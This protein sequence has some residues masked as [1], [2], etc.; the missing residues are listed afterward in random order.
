MNKLL[1]F[2]NGEFTE[3]IAGKFIESFNPSEGTAHLLVADSDQADIEAAV[4]AA[5][6][7][8]PAWSALR[9]EE[10]ARFLYRIADLID[11]R[12]AELARAESDD[13][14][15]PVWLAAEMDIPR[16]AA[17]FRFF[18]GCVLHQEDV[19][20]RLDRDTFNYV[21]R[22]PL[23]VAGLISPWNLPLYLLTWKIA[24]A[25]AYGNTCV[26]K[27][28]ELTSLTASILC[29]IV[30]EAGVPKGVVNVVFGTGPKAGAA[31]VDHPDVPLISFTGGTMTG[32]SI[33]R[34]AAPKF[35]KLSLELGGKNPNIIF[36]DADLEKAV[37]T[38]IRSSFLNQGE[39]CLCGS[40]IYV[41][42]NIHERFLDHFTA[43][44]K[45]L[46]VGDPRNRETF[47]GALVSRDHL[48]K[49]EGFIETA[50]REGVTILTGGRRPA[51][52]GRLSR[53]Y[54]F[55][56]TIL[57]GV[58]HE[59]RL[60]QEEIFGPVVT[61]VPFDTEDEVIGLANGTRY[62]LSATVWTQSLSRAHRVADRLEAG[63][64]WIN[65]WMTRDLRLPFGGVKA[66][67][68]GREGQEHSLDFFTEAKTVCVRHG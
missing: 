42:R 30:R 4:R 1:N 67:G 21:S 26:A 66:S 27:P 52:Q 57:S 53:G 40:R 38:S 51:L 60:I 18:A 3:P 50:R 32:E 12:Q 55:E 14:G 46:E 29:E 37:Q 15:K 10:R 24:P 41:Q 43:K 33:A 35:K 63:T 28:S 25:I 49:I 9:A 44:V 11:S 34:S 8:F 48:A 64:V 47:V 17:N 6:A 54:F 39:I 31:L 36:D 20:T 65:T 5:K 19:A 16:A 23:G 7:A 62:G 45:N 61:V 68:V 22:K 59:S 58:S 56:P 2:I 13:Q